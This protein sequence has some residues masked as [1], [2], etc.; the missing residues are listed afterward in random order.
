MENRQLPEYTAAEGPEGLDQVL[1]LFLQKS[2]SDPQFAAQ[3]HYILYQLSEQKSLIKIDMSQQPFL[4]WY[5][6]LNGRPA[7]EAVKKVIANFLW[8]KGGEKE[9]YLEMPV[10]EYDNG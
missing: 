7:T 5:Y 3:E 10:Q 9:R 4:F 2:K 6:D 1:D 8:E